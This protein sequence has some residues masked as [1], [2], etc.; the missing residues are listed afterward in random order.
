MNAT[1]AA[2]R[3]LTEDVIYGGNVKRRGTSGWAVRFTNT[4]EQYFSTPQLGSDEAYRQAVSWQQRV[5][6]QRGITRCK[7]VA[8]EDFKQYVAGFF[9]GDGC[10]TTQVRKSGKSSIKVSF[11]QAQQDGV[12]D[13]LVAMQKVYGGTLSSSSRGPNTWRNRHTLSFSGCEATWLL[14][15]LDRHTIVKQRQTS[16]ALAFIKSNDDD[17]HAL[18]AEELGLQKELDELNS[19]IVPPHHHNLTD[20][21]LAGLF[22]AEGCTRINGKS[23]DVSI[24]QKS[25]ISL[26]CAIKQKLGYNTNCKSLHNGQLHL[27]GETAERFLDSILPFA[28]VKKDQ[29]TASIEYRRTRFAISDTKRENFVK[30]I[31]QLKKK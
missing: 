23:I 25:S 9:D 10:V 26:L 1:N 27:Y 17:T 30:T 12:P 14:L 22:D 29:V 28:I 21:Y 18:L 20:S 11:T 5:S 16:I 3:A 4:K 2:K 8:N 6:D 31:L 15:D 19:L 13:V 24:A 7:P